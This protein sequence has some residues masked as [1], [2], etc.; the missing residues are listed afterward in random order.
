MNSSVNDVD[1]QRGLIQRIFFDT[2]E[3]QIVQVFV[4]PDKSSADRRMEEIGDD[5]LQNLREA[6]VKIER[7]EGLI[8]EFS[9]NPN[10]KSTSTG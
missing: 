3:N 6:N 5:L 7:F 1:F 2:S 8:S 10:Y 4:W 9:L